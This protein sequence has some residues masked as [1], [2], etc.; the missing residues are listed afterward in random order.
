M[1]KVVIVTTTI[2]SPTLATKKFCEITDRKPN[3]Y[4][5]IVGDT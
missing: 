4:F 3:F 1:K 5:V 2:N